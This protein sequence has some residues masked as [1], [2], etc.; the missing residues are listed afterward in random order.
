MRATLFF[1]VLLC[2]ITS[3]CNEG[4]KNHKKAKPSV[5]KDRYGEKL[6]SL[7]PNLLLEYK[8]LSVGVGVINR[9][10]IEFIKVY[11]EHQKGVKAPQNTLFNIASITKP[12]VATAVLKLVEQGNWDLDEPL[13]K[14]YVDRDVK[15]DSLSRMITTRHCL[16]HT[17]GFKNWRWDEENGKL[18]FNF[19]P[20]E[21]F[22]YS[23]EG[24]EYLR[25][26]I[27][28]KFGIGLEKIVDSLVFE[29][30]KMKD[31]T[32][33]WI[34]DGDTARFAKWYNSKGILHQI[35]HKTE[36]INAADD[37]I[38]TVKDLALFG[39]AIMDQ[40]LLKKSI[41]DEMVKPQSAINKKINQGLGWVVY[42]DLPN[43][44][45]VINHDG[46]DP[47][48]VT[49]LILLPKNENGI[50]VFVNS[51]N[52]AGITNTIT[53]EIMING[54]SIIE[55]LHWDNEIPEEIAI[56]DELLSKYS[57]TYL[58]DREF[59]ITFDKLENTLIT[60]SD[61]FPRL[62]L[63]PKSKNKFFALPYEIYFK[64]IEEE[65]EIK[66]QLLTSENIV[67]LEGLK[68]K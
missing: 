64:F 58:T 25:R 60:E 24:M 36:K 41:Y 42:N 33:G 2:I 50:I 67:E 18:Q 3:S 37:M 44:E 34:K 5:F 51:D 16:S 55:G 54:V 62:K 39:Q 13:Y 12:V 52:G 35:P 9:G 20:G 66:F 65:N 68:Q 47:G 38:L 59:S 17:T 8:A 32:M 22:Q 4:N 10:K 46:G 14:F 29:P 28:S 19:K 26:A 30:L 49:T 21:K 7:I 31:A 23:G 45:I 56:E 48:V 11:G 53:K 61:V 63:F 43:D 27:E 15:E 40:T 57:G 1:F 6:D